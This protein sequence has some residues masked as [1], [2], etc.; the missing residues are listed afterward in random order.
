MVFIVFDAAKIRQING[1]T[2]ESIW[3]KRNM[4]KYVNG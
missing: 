4:E 1:M 2:I 3:T